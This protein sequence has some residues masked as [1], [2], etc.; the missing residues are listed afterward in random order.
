MD[1]V[2]I[3]R[4]SLHSR[5]KMRFNVFEAD[6]VATGSELTYGQLVDTNSSWIADLLTRWGGL[7]RKITIVGDRVDDIASI[8]ETGLREKRKLV[9]ITGGLGPTEDDLT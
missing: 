5:R 7:V 3:N 8:I 9:V 2:V 6:I 4:S 1:K